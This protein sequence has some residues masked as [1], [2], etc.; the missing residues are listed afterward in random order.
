MPALR[1]ETGVP[2]VRAGS[3]AESTSGQLPFASVFEQAPSVIESPIATMACG[4]AA[5]NTCTSD[6]NS[7]CVVVLVALPVGTG[8]V[9]D[10][11][12]LP[13]GER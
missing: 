2:S 13:A 10:D 9:A 12:K 5:A 1:I 3:R 11:V 8:M 6:A 4:V 7:T